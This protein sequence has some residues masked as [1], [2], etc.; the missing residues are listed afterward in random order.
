[1]LVHDGIELVKIYQKR[2]IFVIERCIKNMLSVLLPYL[3]HKMKSLI[4]IL[5]SENAGKF[6]LTGNEHLLSFF[7][8][9]TLSFVYSELI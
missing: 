6:F 8:T 5:K 4:I 9:N 2:K 1:M 3:K 7:T